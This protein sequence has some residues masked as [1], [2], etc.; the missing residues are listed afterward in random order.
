[1]IARAY[2]HPFLVAPLTQAMVV[3][4]SCAAVVRA[5]AS[6]CPNL[7]Y[8]RIELPWPAPEA[9]AEVVWAPFLMHDRLWYIQAPFD[10][11]VHEWDRQVENEGPR[12]SVRKCK[13]VELPVGDGWESVGEVDGHQ[14]LLL[15]RSTF[16]VP[17]NMVELVHRAIIRPGLA[18][19][20]V[21]V[22]S[23]EWEWVRYKQPK[24][25]S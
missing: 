10:V 5:L 13:G 9:P 11:E 16:S 12:Y 25:D 21:G 7:E 20:R 8:L 19:V 14:W 24:R 23:R 4:F 2:V 22:D 18:P 1:V 15:P 3:S 6:G 17:V